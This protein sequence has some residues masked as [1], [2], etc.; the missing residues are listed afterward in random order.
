MGGLTGN[1]FHFLESVYANGGRG[2]FDAVAVH[3]DT[4]CNILSPYSYLRDLDGRIN[5]FSFLGFREVHR[6]MAAH[7]DAR[8][9][10]WMSEMG[11]STSSRTCDVGRWAGQKA[12]GVSLANQAH[13][14]REA[15]HCVTRSGYVANATVFKLRDGAADVPS[16]RF[17]LMAPGGQAKPAFRTLQ[18]FVKHGDTLRGGCGD[19]SGPRLRVLAP[20]H[21]FRFSKDLVIRAVARDGA[22]V[23]RITL[24]ADGHKIRNFT[25]S[26]APRRLSGTIDW[27]GAKRLSPGRHRITVLALDRSRNVSRRTVVVTKL[28][29][30]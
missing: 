17:G 10:I 8:K 20:Q 2:S 11:W 15:L 18:S 13:F 6:T 7:G 25:S 14:L 9:K 30:R 27:Q 19:F 5:Q 24:L 29:R 23:P 26:R 4:A 1:N 21:G 28:P 3:T 16:E 22:G 12:G